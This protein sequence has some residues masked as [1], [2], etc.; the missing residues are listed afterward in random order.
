MTTHRRRPVTVKDVARH[1]GVGQATAARALGAY[2]YVSEAVLARILAA[3]EELGYHRNDLARSMITRTTHTIGLVVAD[4]ENPFFAHL[5]R[6]VADVARQYQYSVL[7]ANSDERVGDERTAVEVFVRKRVDGLIVV[8]A[9]PTADD[10]LLNLVR[11]RTP[12]V[13]VDRSVDGIDVDT[14][15]VDTAGATYEAIRTLTGLGHRRIG[16]VTAS[17][18]I[19]TT[20]NRIAGYRRALTEVGAPA[21]AWIRV[22]ADNSREA[23]QQAA[24]ELLRLHDRPTALIATDSFMTAGVFQAIQAAGLAIPGDL[25][26]IGFDDVEWMSMVKPPITV[27]DQPVSDV[28]RLA[29]E[30]LLARMTGDEGE[31]LTQCLPAHFLVRESCAPP[32]DSR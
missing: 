23:A 20:A 19:S 32:A 25:S 6:A 16:L 2:G 4:V 5:A 14:I 1:A 31:P 24:G 11:R 17:T 26:L 10:H 12:L 28:G 8:P 29:A 15:L 7:L 9:S 27:I 30:R 22:S 13:L 18:A 21:D 3:A